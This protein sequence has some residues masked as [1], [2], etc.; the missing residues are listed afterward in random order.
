[1]SP[2]DQIGS[3]LVLAGFIHTQSVGIAVMR[4]LHAQPMG[5]LG[6]V[7]W[8]HKCVFFIDRHF[9]IKYAY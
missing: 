2:V 6:G 1:M 7:F 5:Y 8:L 4:A 9:N 3:R